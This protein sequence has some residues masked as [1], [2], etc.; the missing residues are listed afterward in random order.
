MGVDYVEGEPL[1]WINWSSNQACRP[2]ERLAP[3]TEESLVELLT[4]T[5][6]SIR[7]VG[8]GHSFSALV[9][10]D[11]SLVATDLLSGVISTDDERQQAEVWSGTRLHQ[12]GPALEAHGQAL[13]N[14]PDIDYQTIAGATATSTHGTGVSMGSLSSLVS[15]MTLVTP[16]G[17]LVQCSR[18]NE[19]DLF[20]AAQCGLG[21]LGV[22]SRVVIDTVPKFDLVEHSSFENVFDILEDIEAEKANNR[23]F[24][25]LVFPHTSI[26]LVIRT[27]EA[28]ES[29]PRVLTPEDPTAVY[30]IRDAYQSL[31][32]VP[33]VG[34]YLYDFA[35]SQ[36]LDGEAQVRSGAS[37]VVLTHDR[38]VRF[39]E[40]EYTVPAEVGPDCVQEILDTIKSKNIPVV[41]PI[42]YR[43]VQADDVWMSMFY[44]QDGCSISVHQFADE[45]HRAYFAEIEP[46]FW[47]YGGRPHWGKLHTLDHSE[48]SKLYPHWKDFLAVR[49]A[50]DP[51]GRMLNTHLKQ[52]LGV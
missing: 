23:H 12:L 11:G 21:A 36:G 26:A 14:L 42:E 1:P 10:T 39:R 9:P 16:K 47:K 22:A 38:V 19:P 3:A 4:Q 2:A 13:T 27:N 45:D 30:Q 5:S 34:D 31:G 29:T 50:V 25:F 40:M 18:E 51:T 24:E 41:F 48:L 49:E 33:V 46:I 15:G 8:S 37:H 7:P 6:G 52:L 17:E 44:E 35:L 32:T 20:R 43:Y 28:D